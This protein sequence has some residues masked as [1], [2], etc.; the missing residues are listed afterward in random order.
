MKVIKRPHRSGSVRM[1][2]NKPDSS[3]NARDTNVESFVPLT[4]NKEEVQTKPHP[5]ADTFGQF[6]GEAWE[7]HRAM[8]QKLRQQDAEDNL[9]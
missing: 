7:E 8:L 3:T 1:V 5:L 2:R 4:I 9:E 6:E